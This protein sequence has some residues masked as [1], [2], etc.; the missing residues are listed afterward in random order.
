MSQA[1]KNLFTQFIFDHFGREDDKTYFIKTGTFSSKFYF[2][3]AKCSEPRE[4]GEYFQ[5]INNFAMLV[6][7]A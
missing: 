4:M 5:V 2:T 1:D 3:N 7:G 6:G